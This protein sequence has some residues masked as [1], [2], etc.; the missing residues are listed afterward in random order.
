MNQ[1]STEQR[2]VGNYKPMQ[3]VKPAG[4]HIDKTTKEQLLYLAQN[5]PLVM[6][7]THEEHWYTKAEL[8]E[9]GWV[10]ATE[11]KDGLYKVKMPV[12]V[13][14]N[15]YRCMRRRFMRHGTAGVSRYIDE[16]KALPNA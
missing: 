1:L 15:H 13:A 4:F 7:A 16:I 10:G 6:V 11:F 3:A 12:Q 2:N 9:M 8:E 14:K 5:M